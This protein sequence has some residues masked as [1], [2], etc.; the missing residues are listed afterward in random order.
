MFQSPEGW[1]SSNLHPIPGHL[2]FTKP[3]ALCVRLVGLDSCRGNLGDSLRFVVVSSQEEI[4]DA[5]FSRLPWA[6]ASQGLA[7]PSADKQRPVK[8]SVPC[9][10]RFILNAP[11][12]ASNF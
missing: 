6:R 3:S 2:L 4:W 5:D 1:P 8:L 9:L 11:A 7:P 10:V 12:A